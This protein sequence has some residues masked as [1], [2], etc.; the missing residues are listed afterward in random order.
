MTETFIASLIPEKVKQLGYSKYHLRYRDL[1]IKQNSKVVIN[2]WNNLFFLVDDPQ[3]ISIESEYG[4]YDTTGAYIS[5][6]AHLHRGEIEIANPQN[7]SIRVKF[8][9]VI[10]IS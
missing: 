3:G 5:D 10:I 8:I 1:T 6:N 2:G 4:I 7:C 9:Q